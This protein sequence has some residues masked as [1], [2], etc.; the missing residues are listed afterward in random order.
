MAD[1]D[2]IVTYVKVGGQFVQALVATVGELKKLGRANGTDETT[3][4]NLDRA[5]T[6]RIEREKK[7]VG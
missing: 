1:K 5:L 7:V 3:L 2:Q 6:D 4:S